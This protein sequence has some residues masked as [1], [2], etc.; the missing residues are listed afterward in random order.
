MTRDEIRSALQAIARDVFEDDNLEIADS[1]G[2]QDIKGWDS[3]GH[4]R[5]I[6]ATEEAFGITFTLEEIE[7]AKSMGQIVAFVSERA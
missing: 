7:G 2:P 6:S 3:L 5:L 1:L 4:I